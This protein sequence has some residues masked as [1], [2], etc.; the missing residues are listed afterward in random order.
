MATILERGHHMKKERQYRVTTVSPDR[1]LMQKFMIRE[2]VSARALSSRDNCHVSVEP[3]REALHGL[4]MSTWSLFLILHSLQITKKEMA[5]TLKVSGDDILHKYITIDK[6]E[7]SD[8]AHL[9]NLF[10]RLGLS[11]GDDGK[12]L[13]VT[14]LSYIAKSASIDISVE[15]KAVKRLL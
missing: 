12:H 7:K 9:T 10:K 5:E 6:K 15:L 4:P 14:T 2:G 8:E 1:D 13:L 11:L 3:V